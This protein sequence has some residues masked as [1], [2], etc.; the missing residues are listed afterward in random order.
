MRL[1]LS[2]ESSKDS[3]M[4]A[5]SAAVLVTWNRPRAAR[6]RKQVVFLAF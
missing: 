6:V 5:F 2:I 1:A 4:M 3:R